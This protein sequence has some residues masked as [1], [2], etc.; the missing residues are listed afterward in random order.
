MNYQR[1]E[2]DG[3]ET[4]R[5]KSISVH[6]KSAFIAYEVHGCRSLSPSADKILIMEVASENPSPKVRLIRIGLGA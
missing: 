3:R 6:S 5:S 4:R 2:P 1:V